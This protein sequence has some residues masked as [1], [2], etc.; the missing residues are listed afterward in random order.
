[1][2]VYLCGEKGCCPSVTIGTDHVEIGEE[3]NKCTLTMDEWSELK[4]QI[5]ENKI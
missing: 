4:A 1:M 2:K 5:K 3:G